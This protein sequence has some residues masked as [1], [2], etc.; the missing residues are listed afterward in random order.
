[1]TQRFTL[2]DLSPEHRRQA[3]AQID[4]N[5]V[6]ATETAYVDGA[7]HVRFITEEPKRKYRNEPIVI[8]G[9]RFDSKF[10]AQRWRELQ[11]QVTTGLI[12]QL[13]RQVEFSLDAWTRKGPRRVGAYIADFTYELQGRLVVEDAKSEPTRKHSTYQLKRKM[14]EAQYDIEIVEVMRPKR[15]LGRRIESESRA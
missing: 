12:T 8:D 11:N 1:M 14:F 7:K 5:P 6:V 15:R 9:E 10:E 2:G 13:H 4:G 3:L